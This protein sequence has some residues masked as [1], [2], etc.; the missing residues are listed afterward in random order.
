MQY[1]ESIAN[2]IASCV[3]FDDL[4]QG[5]WGC[6]ISGVIH[7]DST[8]THTCHEH[9]MTAIVNIDDYYI[10]SIESALDVFVWDKSCKSYSKWIH[11]CPN[12]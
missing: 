7:K 6:A 11:W 1:I 3:S 5:I 2:S 12:K 9:P 10:P 4:G 8:S